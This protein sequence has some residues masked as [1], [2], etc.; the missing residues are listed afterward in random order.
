MRNFITIITIFIS[1]FLFSQSLDSLTFDYINQYRIKND[2]KPLLW[3][4]ELYKNCIKHSNNMVLNDSVYHSHDYT[5]SEN[6]AYGKNGGFLIT[7][8]YKIF[9]KKYY[10]LSSDDVLKD[11]SIF[12]TTQ[13]VYGWYISKGHDKIM[14]SDGKYGAV[15]VLLKNVIK[16]NNVVFGHELFKGSGPFYYKGTVS[17]TF[18]IK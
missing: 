9:I 8:D 3:S 7:D 13:V 15:H 18:Q 5:C 12:W 17:E 6:V 4:N 1:P 10:N 14:L 11:V 16:K 2:K